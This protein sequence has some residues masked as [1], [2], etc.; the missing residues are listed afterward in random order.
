MG[1]G[2]KPKL[3]IA[4][5]LLYSDNEISLEYACREWSITL[6]E[7]DLYLSPSRL[8]YGSA[9]SESGDFSAALRE[10][11]LQVWSEGVGTLYTSKAHLEMAGLMRQTT[12]NTTGTLIQVQAI[13]IVPYR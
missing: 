4:N 6:C 7:P 11:V 1:K 10:L 9:M 5:S 12:E 13:I 3:M 2:W 8:H